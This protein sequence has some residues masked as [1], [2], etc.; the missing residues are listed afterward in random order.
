MR[1]QILNQAQVSFGFDRLSLDSLDAATTQSTQ[2]DPHDMSHQIYRRLDQFTLDYGLAKKAHTANTLYSFFRTMT[3][4][5]FILGVISVINYFIKIT[6]LNF[7]F[8]I[9]FTLIS[10][11]AAVSFLFRTKNMGQRYIQGVLYVMTKNSNVSLR[12]VNEDQDF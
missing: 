7:T 6:D 3:L 8:N 1:T 12:T 5:T 10:F 11:I 4:V 9:I 2:I